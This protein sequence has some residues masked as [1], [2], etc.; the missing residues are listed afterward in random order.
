MYNENKNLL[1]ICE[2]IPA[3]SN[4]FSHF[5]SHI[6]LLAVRRYVGSVFPKEDNLRLRHWIELI[7]NSMSNDCCNVGEGDIFLINFST[8]TEDQRSGLFKLGITTHA[9]YYGKERQKQIIDFMIN[10]MDGDG[11]FFN[12][13]G[14]R[15]IPQEV[16]NL[17][18][19][20]G[21][22]IRSQPEIGL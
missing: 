21:A 2:K 22:L 15:C 10:N 18:S 16:S 14:G 5:D 8:L 1:E 4:V 9:Y 12:D 20:Y 17:I 7:V 19:N 11:R 13:P 3:Y 6:Y